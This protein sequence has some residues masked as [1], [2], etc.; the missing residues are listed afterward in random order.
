VLLPLEK[1][2]GVSEVCIGA[3]NISVVLVFF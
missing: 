1:P 2:T 3:K